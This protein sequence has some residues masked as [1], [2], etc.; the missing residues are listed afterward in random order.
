MIESSSIALGL[1]KRVV[2]LA[3]MGAGGNIVAQSF[4]A[5]G[6]WVI[7]HSCADVDGTKQVV[8]QVR[9]NGGRAIPAISA[10]NDAGSAW[11][12]IERII[13]EWGQLD[14]LICDLAGLTT[15]SFWTNGAESF[16]PASVEHL[17]VEALKRMRAQASGK[18]VFLLPNL[19]DVPAIPDQATTWLEN[20][21][22]CGL[23]DNV[24]VNAVRQSSW[25]ADADLARV[26]IFLGSDWSKGVSN[27]CL[28]LRNLSALGQAS[29]MDTTH[30]RDSLEC[31]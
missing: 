16:I 5:S 31:R 18:I 25:A 13:A 23:D 21:S 20:L 26:L 6:A 7:V 3:G 1:E 8:D 30:I 9:S 12:L 2:L 29:T 19:E 24:L 22:K 27:S 15:N 14:V 4:A 28:Q 10:L 17:A 11:A